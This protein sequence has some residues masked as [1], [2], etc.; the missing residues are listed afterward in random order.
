MANE[1]KFEVGSMYE[2][3]KG[4][5]EVISI[6]SEEMVIRWNNGREVATSI[7]LQSRI[8]ERMAQEKEFQRQKEIEEQIKAE[9]NKQKG[10][11]GFAGFFEGDFKNTSKNT[12]W[13][14]RNHIG[15]AVSKGLHS[16]EIELNSWAVLM[17]PEVR[18]MEVN[19]H[20]RQGPNYNIGFLARVNDKHLYYGM[21]IQHSP[22]DRDDEL[23]GWSPFKLWLTGNENENWLKQVAAN[24]DLTIYDAS[25]KGFTRDIKFHDEN[26]ELNEDKADNKIE[27]LS[28]FFAALSDAK[29]IDL[30]IEKMMTKEEAMSK[31]ESIVGEIATLFNTLMP[32]YEL[33]PILVDAK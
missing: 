30:R 13:R 23:E 10:I 9:K 3:M 12:V 27:S 28:S 26:W 6:D 2:N 16:E 29:P 32:L 19:R 5:Y 31:G 7:D 14:R 25:R 11:S 18:W 1:L 17:R 24:H 21:Y 15:A 20:K 33:A 8:I 22:A 4:V